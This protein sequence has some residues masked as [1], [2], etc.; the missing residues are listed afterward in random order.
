MLGRVDYQ[1]GNDV[2]FFYRFS[3]FNKFLDA[4]SGAGYS[5]YDTKNN[6]RDHVLG[7]DFKTGSFIHS[8]RFS[9]LKFQNQ[10]VD[11]TAGNSALPLNNL[12]VQIIIWAV[13]VWQPDRTS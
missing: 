3:Y 8:I 6:T 13:L 5:L 1:W 7:V 9:F 12:G 11:A 2:H 10:I 4:T